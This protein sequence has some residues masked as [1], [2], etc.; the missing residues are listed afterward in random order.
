MAFTLSDLVKVSGH[1][2]A[3]LGGT[4]EYKEAATIATIVASAYMNAASGVLRI[5]DVV[6]VRGSD[7]T[8]IR[9]VTSATGATPVT[10]GA[11][12]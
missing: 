6:V 11:L 5:G 1:A 8:G 3:P 10:L 12:G 4:Y 7:G 9:Q 2:N